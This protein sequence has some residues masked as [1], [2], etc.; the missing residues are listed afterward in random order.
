MSAQKESL[1]I[2]GLGMNTAVKM[3]IVCEK[4]QNGKGSEVQII[5]DSF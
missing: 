3:S 1:F 5:T 4:G 2:F